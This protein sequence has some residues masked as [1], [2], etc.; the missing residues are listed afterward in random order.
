LRRNCDVQKKY[1]TRIKA[2]MT[3]FQVILNDATTG[4]KLQGSPK[5]QIIIQTVD[6]QTSG[7]IYTAL[8]RVR[9]L[10][11]LFL[12]SKIDFRQFS[13]RYETTRADLLAFDRRMQ[14][15]VP[16]GYGAI[17]SECE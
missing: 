12:T 16:N 5:N 14:A 10:E 17:S 3:Q 1:R 2:K 4:Y 11:G 15:K 13:L 6:Y 8:S 7:W 9:C